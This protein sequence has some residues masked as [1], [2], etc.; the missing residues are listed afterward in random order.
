MHSPHSPKAPTFH[1]STSRYPVSKPINHPTY[2]IHHL[3]PAIGTVQSTCRSLAEMLA[4]A[5][6]LMY[7]R[8]CLRANFGYFGGSLE[9]LASNPALPFSGLAHLTLKNVRLM[10]AVTWDARGPLETAIR[11]LRTE[12]GYDLPHTSIVADIL[13]NPLNY[14]T[15]ALLQRYQRSTEG[16]R[17]LAADRLAGLTFK[18]LSGLECL[19]CHGTGLSYEISSS[20]ITRADSVLRSVILKYKLVI[21]ENFLIKDVELGGVLATHRYFERIHPLSHTAV[22]LSKYNSSVLS[23]IPQIIGKK[24]ILHFTDTVGINI[25]RIAGHH[26]VSLR[27]LNLATDEVSHQP[28]LLPRDLYADSLLNYS[29]VVGKEGLLRALLAKLTSAPCNVDDFQ[30]I[31]D[32]RAQGIANFGFD[33]GIRIDKGLWKLDPLMLAV[34]HRN[35]TAVDILLESPFSR[36]RSCLQAELKLCVQHDYN[37]TPACWIELAKLGPAH[38][39]VITGQRPLLQKILSTRAGSF[40][41]EDAWS[42]LWLASQA[43]GPGVI[44]CLGLLS[45]SDDDVLTHLEHLKKRH[46][47]ELLRAYCGIISN[48]RLNSDILDVIDAEISGLITLE[49]HQTSI[50]QPTLAQ[51][52]SVPTRGVSIDSLSDLDLPPIET[53]IQEFYDVPM[54][55][56]GEDTTVTHDSLHYKPYD[57]RPEFRDYSTTPALRDSTSSAVETDA[58]PEYPMSDEDLMQLLFDLPHSYFV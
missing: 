32:T 23:A 53:F 45:L 4:D 43:Q 6:C 10:A 40:D 30:V 34:L 56:V 55:S 50:Q 51:R 12:L 20:D 38:I 58:A 5:D 15:D 37:N 41:A 31:F 7:L 22:I 25:H 17:N 36:S 39:A 1:G 29:I 19:A 35:N 2:D 44:E 52:S 57:T 26:G 18:W 48:L 42:L 11:S 24:D 47:P 28:A 21:S 46:T 13:N 49:V 9:D 33:E 14:E 27:H 3:V 54:G 8:R 16:T